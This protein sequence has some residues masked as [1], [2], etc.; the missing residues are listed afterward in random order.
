[1]DKLFLK[2]LPVFILLLVVLCT[3]GTDSAYAAV[4]FSCGT[5]GNFNSGGAINT[6]ATIS[7]VHNLTMAVAGGLTYNAALNGP[8]TGT[9]ITC[10]ITGGGNKILY[11][12]YCDASDSIANNAGC[13]GVT[14]RSITSF[15]V[16]SQTQGPHMT[17]KVC[18]G[19]AGA[20][21]GTLKT[22]AGGTAVITVGAVM[23]ATHVKIGSSYK[24]SNHATGLFNIKVI[25]QPTS[26]TYGPVTKD[27][28]VTFTSLVGF[29]S[30]TGMNFANMVG[31]AVPVAGDH[32]DLGT[33]GTA[34]YNGAFTAQPGGALSAGAVKMN[35][36]QDG[37]TVEIYCDTTIHMTNGGAASINVTGIKVA[38]QGSTGTYAGAGTACTGSGAGAPATTMVYAAGTADTFF[39]GGKLDGGTAAAFSNATIYR[40]T[41]AGGTPATVI[42]L[43]Q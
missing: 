23:D 37:V 9:P 12:V 41:N 29:S 21:A 10:T 5:A 43:N 15:N 38:A 30:T 8:A 4:A 24:L 3:A 26:T 20:M 16:D 40:S 39:L 32:V 2:H 22:D 28:S 17:N 7:G 27:L 25:D 6:Q 11:D 33:D 35:N 18:N 13:C 1:M 19:L 42:V 14:N 31:P 34:V 36:V